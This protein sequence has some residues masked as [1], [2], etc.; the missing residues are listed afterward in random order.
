MIIGKVIKHILYTVN[1]LALLLLLF[2]AF[3]D[4]ISPQLWL[5]PSFMGIL[6]P[7]FLFINIAFFLLW[8]ASFQ[9]KAILGNAI[10]FLISWGS[11]RTYYP[12]NAPDTKELPKDAIKLMT[13]N[14]MG[15]AYKDHTADQPNPIIEYINRENPD[16]ICFQEYIVYKNKQILN[17]RTIN[18]ALN[19]YPY[20]RTMCFEQDA[21]HD[22]GIAI[23]S[24]F[25][26]I[27]S[28]RIN[29]QSTF[30]GSGLFYINVH[31][32]KLAIINNHLESNRITQKDK[33]FYRSLRH[34]SLDSDKLGLLKQNIIS[35]L[36]PAFIQRAIQADSISNKIKN[37]D[38]DYILICGDLNDTP[39]SY[40]RHK[41]QGNLTDAYTSTNSGAGIS[42]NADYFWFRI[43]YIFHT[44][45]IDS[46]QCSVGKT[47]KTSDHYPLSCYFTLK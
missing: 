28:E 35:R 37:I 9:W 15:F 8:L 29:Y 31:N 20:K 40:A 19:N 12:I 2:S 36:K 13:Y 5:L 30:N 10:I 17:E 27:A 34:G 16:I 23:Y 46:Y 45:S 21:E 38:T 1:I 7:F 42:Y 6:F 39:I 44:S 41:I 18:K 26:I 22:Y 24:K 25:P 4:R 47:I 3:S 32:K 11:I 14:V 43:D 33:E